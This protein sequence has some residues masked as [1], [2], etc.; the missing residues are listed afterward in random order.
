MKNNIY[1]LQSAFYAL[2]LLVNHLESDPNLY[3][4]DDDG[5]LGR[6]MCNAHGVL[7]MF[8]SDDE[9]GE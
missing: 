3:D 1:K 4:G 8:K 9:G 7:N 6:V 5:S 2:Q